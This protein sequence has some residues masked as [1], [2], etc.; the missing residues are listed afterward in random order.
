MAIRLTVRPLDAQGRLL[1]TAGRVGLR[2][3]GVSRG[4]SP[5]PAGLD[6]AF[7]DLPEHRVY[8]ATVTA[9]GFGTTTKLINVSAADRSD[10]VLCFLRRKHTLPRFPA[11]QD[12]DR[13][14]RQ[15]LE[16]STRLDRLEHDRIP[17]ERAEPEPRIVEIRPEPDRLPAMRE[18][19]AP[20]DGERR[21]LALTPE[22]Q[23][24]LLN[25]FA[26]MSSIEL[27][28]E[29]TV[30]SHVLELDHVEQDRVYVLVKPTLAPKARATHRFKEADSSLHKPPA[31]FRAAGSVKTEERYGNLQLTFFTNDSDVM[32]DADVDEAAGLEHGEQVLRNWIYGGVRKALGGVVDDLPEGKTHPYDVHQ[33]LVF[34]QLGD[35]ARRPTVR[36]Y[37]ACYALRLR[38]GPPGYEIASRT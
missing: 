18:P 17:P 38:G 15:A 26:K 1:P 33:I 10:G 25:L 4:E 34:H 30:W 9:T 8:A 28:D 32:V 37:R 3:D 14:L 5:C 16:R 27:L 6:V 36:P 31:G 7:L 23:A 24:G 20:R 21:W 22:Q 2:L 12:L 19:E 11:F 35:D 29:T 13:S